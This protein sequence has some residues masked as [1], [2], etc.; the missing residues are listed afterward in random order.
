MLSQSKPSARQ[1][2]RER[3]R[4]V[5][6]A[7]KHEDEPPYYVEPDSLGWWFFLR[8]SDETSVSFSS[9]STQLDRIPEYCIRSFHAVRKGE[10]NPLSVVDESLAKRFRFG[11][12]TEEGGD[13]ILMRAFNILKRLP[14][15]PLD[16][17]SLHPELYSQ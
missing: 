17:E 15:T 12:D 9:R 1:D 5:W 3:I 11:M 10:R 7:V 2:L 14:T 16:L 8:G 6:E 13:V 4:T